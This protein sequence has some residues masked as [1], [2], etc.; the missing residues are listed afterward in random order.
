M[1]RLDSPIQ[2][3]WEVGDLG[4]VHNRD[5][6]IANPFRRSSGTQEFKAEVMKPLGEVDNA[7][8]IGNGQ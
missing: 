8:F 5:P 3:L 7:R 2:H 4:N 6:S 1:E